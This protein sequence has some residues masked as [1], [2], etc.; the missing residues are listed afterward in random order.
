MQGYFTQAH[1]TARVNA[2]TAK[3]SA[4]A[5]LKLQLPIIRVIPPVLYHLHDDERQDSYMGVPQ[6]GNLLRISPI[7]VVNRGRTDA[8]GIAIGLGWQVAEKL[9]GKPS[10]GWTMKFELERF[11]SGLSIRAEDPDF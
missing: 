5:A 2:E 6:I 10:Y 8:E 11:S 9:V 7:K 3:R 4:E 1:K